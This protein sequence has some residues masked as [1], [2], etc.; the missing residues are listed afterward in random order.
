MS[1]RPIN[2][3][4]VPDASSL[5]L[6]SR[7][8]SWLLVSVLVISVC[9]L[10]YELIIGALSS[11]LLG[12]SVTHFSVT[13]GLFLFA[14]GLGSYA[15][16]W[17]KRRLLRAFIMVE[18]I[19]GIA[20]GLSATVLYVAFAFSDLYYVAMV[21]AILIIGGCMGMEI[22]L[23]TRLCS[24]RGNLRD[25][26]ANI[27][28]IDYLGALF[29][30]LLF[31]LV[32][33]PLLGLLSTSYAIGLLNLAV[34][35][36]MVVAF[37]SRLPHWRRLIVQTSLATLLLLVG[38][39]QAGFLAQT[40]ESKLY[41]D[42]VIYARQSAYQRIV[43]TRRGGDLRLFLDG[44]LQFSLVDE[45][46][47]HESLV[48][49]AMSL[50]P[51]PRRV[52]I[53]G[54][55]DGLALRQVLRHPAVETVDL[56]DLDPAV[57]EL[58]RTQHALREANEDALHDSR[59]TIHNVDAFNFVEETREPYE[60]ILCDLPDPRNESLSKLY[61]RAFY[62]MLG[63]QLAPG[64]ILA[65]QATSPFFAREAYWAIIQTARSADLLVTPYHTYVPSFGDWGFF[66]ASHG[67]ID[68]AAYTPAV[69]VRFLTSDI[70]HSALVF[71]QDVSEIP[72]ETSTLDHPMVLTYYEKGWQQWR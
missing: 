4:P 1:T 17:V 67:P 65:A 35:I 7:Q 29:G 22:P 30:S 72:T 14:M 70:F 13:I 41:D 59:V 33:L 38:L 63:Q 56:V 26:L 58:G 60:V 62:G 5:E 48:H 24:S 34:A 54:G 12:S 45:Y 15:S 43:M 47:Y 36:G 6:S 31:P 42:A 9:G 53:L 55:G 50:A 10:V 52:L 27:F 64:G 20:G 3:D 61:S 32:L 44:S 51:T 40:L 2:G 71:A 19:I 8:V 57:T 28:S 66:L 25:N 37:R 68:P 16:R 39:V 49:P 11:Y 21:T 46:R 23:L 18:I 69:P